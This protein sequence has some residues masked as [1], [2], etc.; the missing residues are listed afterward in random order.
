MHTAIRVTADLKS[1]AVARRSVAWFTE[2][3]DVDTATAA[4]IATE[5]VTNAVRHGGEPI[6]L[7]LRY[8]HGSLFVE[9][10]DNGCGA[11]RVRA[12]EERRDGDG[13][14]M[15]LVLVE[16]LSRAW[17]VR[18]SPRGCKTVWA[19]LACAPRPHGPDDSAEDPD[20]LVE[21]R[22]QRE[23]QLADFERFLAVGERKLS[24]QVKSEAAIGPRDAA[25]R[26][27]TDPEWET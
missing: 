20:G 19:E 9:V 16:Q 8:E 15:G 14:G 21:V 25:L 24:A 7:H 26:G 12:E 10:S 27:S 5:L 18:E 2:G 17:G 13:G 11:P 22:A 3:L 1:A 4:L 6:V 23:R